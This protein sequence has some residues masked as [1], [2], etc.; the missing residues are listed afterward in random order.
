MDV[1]RAA[2]GRLDETDYGAVKGAWLDAQRL[3]LVSR[4][5]RA[6]AAETRAC[7]DALLTALPAVH[8]DATPAVRAAGWAVPFVPSGSR[9]RLTLRADA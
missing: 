5:L 4:S 1:L 8:A 2:Q 3:A 9:L 6:T 7:A